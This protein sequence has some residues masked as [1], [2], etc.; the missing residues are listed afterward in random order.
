MKFEEGMPF[1]G[2]AETGETVRDLTD[3]Y[4]DVCFPNTVLGDHKLITQKAVVG[5]M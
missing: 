1:I 4:M 5:H 3:W 2:R